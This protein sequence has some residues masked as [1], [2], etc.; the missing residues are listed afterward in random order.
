MI[1]LG[2]DALVILVLGITLKLL[3]KLAKESS[4]R[5]QKSRRGNDLSSL[6]D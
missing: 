1:E 6:E 4:D 2:V 3:G 5:Q